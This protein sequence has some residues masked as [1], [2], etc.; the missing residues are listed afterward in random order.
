MAEDF[1]QIP[2]PNCLEELRTSTGSPQ[3]N[4]GREDEVARISDIVCQHNK[5]REISL[6]FSFGTPCDGHVSNVDGQQTKFE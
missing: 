6:L 1:P 3:G 2:V 4:G 5:K